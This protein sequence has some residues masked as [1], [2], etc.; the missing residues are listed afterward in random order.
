MTK[1]CTLIEHHNNITGVN[2]KITSIKLEVPIVTL[3][4]DKS[5]KFL[6]N[7]KVQKNNIVKQIHIRNSNT[8]Q[9]QQVRFHD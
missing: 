1:G 7:L 6:E 2:F 8:T 4:I 5:I 3:T 9:K